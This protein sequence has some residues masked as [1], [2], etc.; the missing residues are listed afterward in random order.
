MWL[1]LA[2]LLVGPFSWIE[3]PVAV[4]ILDGFV[5]LGFAAF[6]LTVVALVGYHD[7]GLLLL[8]PFVVGI[9]LIATPVAI[10]VAGSTT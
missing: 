6:A 9:I 5:P 4:G 2:G 3:G 8:V 7:H 10:A 1:L